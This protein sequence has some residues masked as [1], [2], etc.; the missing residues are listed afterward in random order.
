MQLDARVRQEVRLQHKQQANL[1]SGGTDRAHRA[2]AAAACELRQVTQAHS[3]TAA[4]RTG[5]F[6]EG[7]GG[8][9]CYCESVGKTR[10][11]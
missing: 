11:P 2:A 5:M 4:R 8:S 7:G 3:C 6:V 1:E 9:D 10:R